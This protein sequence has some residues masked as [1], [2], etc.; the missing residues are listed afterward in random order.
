[1]I[2]PIA[3]SISA[4]NKAFQTAY[5]D[6]TSEVALAEAFILARKQ[7]GMSQQVLAEALKTQQPAIARLESGE[8]AKSSIEKLRAYADILGY[9]LQ[10]SLVKK[11]D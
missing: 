6:L 5:T 2:E 1:M 10:I 8:F 11:T 7:A 9:T 3:P 4:K